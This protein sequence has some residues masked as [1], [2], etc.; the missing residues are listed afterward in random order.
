LRKALFAC[1]LI[2]MPLATAP[3]EAQTPEGVWLHVDR[4]IQ[5]EIVPCGELL[6]CGN[7]VWFMWPNDAEGLPLVD[8]KNPDL[9]LRGRPL[10]GLQIL[11][12][13]RRTGVNTWEDGEIYNPDDGESYLVQMSIEDDGTLRVRAY[14]LVPMFG[15]TQIWTRF[16]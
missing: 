10:L 14:V 11:H 12:G 6:L 5:V 15:K 7:L 2:S 8:L 1:A 13:L 9:A 3:A 16:P 4:R